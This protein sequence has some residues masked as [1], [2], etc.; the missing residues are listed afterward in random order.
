[1]ATSRTAIS[2][3]RVRPSTKIDWWVTIGLILAFALRLYRLDAQSIWVDEGISLH[4]ATSS[5]GEIVANRAANIHPPLYFFLLKGWLAL[6]GVSTTTARSLSAMASLLQ[7]ATIYAVTDHWLGK[8]TARIAALLTALSPLS[9]IY[10]QEIRTYAILPLIY[11]ALIDITRRLVSSPPD[12]NK[13]QGIR[14]SRHNSLTWLPLGAVEVIGLHLHYT[15]IFLVA[16]V[17]GWT[18]LSLWRGKRWVDLRSWLI[19]Q[20]LVGLASLPWL[21]AVLT[22]W[23]TVKARATGS[24]AI[25][26]SLPLKYLLA[27]I[28]V[29]HVTGRAGALGRPPLRL[30]SGSL[31]LTLIV[32]LLFRLIRPSTRRTAVRLLAHWL[33]PLSATLLVW[34]IRPYSHPRYISLFTPGLTIV[35]AYLLCSN[36]ELLTRLQVKHWAFRFIFLGPQVLLAACLV[37]PSLVS[38]GGYFF[39]PTVAKDD[40]RGVARYLEQEAKPDDLILVPDGDWSLSFLYQGETPIEMPGVANEERMWADLALWTA[41]RR[42]VFLMNYKHGFGGDQREMVPFALEAAGALSRRQS[43]GNVLIRQYQLD[44]LIR[45]PPMLPIDANFGS[46]RLSQAWAENEPPADTALTL[47]LRW[48]LEEPTDERYGLTLRLL[49]IDGWPVSIRDGLLLD[50]HIHPSDRWAAGQETTTYHTLVIPPG[51]PP[52]SYSLSIGLY[53]QTKDGI[54]PLDLLSDQGVPQGQTLNVATVLLSQPIGLKDNPYGLSSTPSLT[55]PVSLADGLALLGAELDR[56]VLSPGESLFV[57]L[58][59]QATRS[60][61]P[62]YRPRLALIQ[63]SRELD[64]VESAPALGRYPT[65]LWQAQEQVVEHRRLKAPPT[66][67]PGVAD[68]VLTLGS[69][70]MTLGQVDLDTGAHLFT[71]PTIAHPLDIRFDQAALLIGYDLPSQEFTSAQP[72]TITLYWQALENASD[73]DYTVFTHILGPDGHLVGQHDSPPVQ[74]ARPTLGWIPDEIIVDRHPMVFREPY[75]GSAR[76][77]VGLYNPV[78]MERL[79]TESGTDSFLLPEELTVGKP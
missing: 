2:R 24:T 9:V 1:M 21:I 60:S 69:S 68:V 67:A 10:A 76:V 31:F 51:T 61:L 34:I 8:A 17:S 35:T 50:E 28:W 22:H 7:V 23:A 42:R 55:Q 30:A 77:E 73:V 32:L 72:I 29:F 54:N 62:D 25:T 40:I 11:L 38:L 4:L 65:N 78:S 41:Q 39:D 45:P 19:T 64:T 59:W 53:E 12:V 70:R 3:S 57:T 15:A 36:P 74:G 13:L 16:Y 71:P 47:A 14:S 66:I 26:E 33:L 18:L 63:A 79:Q 48:Y 46:M 49:D 6:T 58:R 37:L 44:Q 52:L 20:L 75:A 5:L 56:S 43:F 27:Q